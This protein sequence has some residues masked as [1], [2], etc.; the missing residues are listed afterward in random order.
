[1]RLQATSFPVLV[2]SAKGEKIKA[3]ATGS[4]TTCEFENVFEF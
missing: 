4:T 3:K 1:M 2:L